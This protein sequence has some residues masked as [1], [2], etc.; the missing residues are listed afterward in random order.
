MI[1]GGELLGVVPKSF[2]PNYREFYEKRYFAH[3][4]D[5]TD[6]WIAVAGEEVPFGTDLVFAA[7]N[8]PGFRFGVEICED[9]W[10]PIPPGM[11]AALA[12]ALILC[13]LSASPIT[14]G[15]ADDRHLHLPPSQR[16]PRDCGPY[17][18]SVQAAT[19]RAPPILAWD[20]QR[21][22]LTNGR[23]AGRKRAV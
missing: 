21:R 10:A 2:L 20:G 16:Q 1:A 22:D 3:G 6:L 19:A 23:P 14:I 12:G 4:R 5:C 15:R 13:N 11:T 17:V 9:Y 18:Y 7:A 8:L